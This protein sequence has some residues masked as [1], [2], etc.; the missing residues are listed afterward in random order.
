MKITYDK[1]SDAAYIQF[2]IE[3]AEKLEHDHVEGEWPINIDISK[4]GKVMGIEILDASHVLS[5]KVLET[6]EI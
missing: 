5:P 2:D 3:D 6:G 1:S 4:D